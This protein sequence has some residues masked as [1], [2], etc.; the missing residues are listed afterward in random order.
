MADHAPPG[1]DLRD[2]DPEIV[3][4]TLAG[5]AVML[6]ISGHQLVF[7]ADELRERIIPKQEI[8]AA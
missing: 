8:R 3:V 7:R 2:A 1:T 6:E 5:D 4:V